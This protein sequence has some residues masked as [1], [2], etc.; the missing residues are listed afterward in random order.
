MSDPLVH[1]EQPE[2]P[3]DRR[4][5][6]PPIIFNIK[7]QLRSLLALPGGFFYVNSGLILAADNEAELAGVM[8]HEIAHVAA[9]H[10][11]RQATRG[12]IANLATIPLIFV[13]G[14][15]GYGAQSASSLLIPMGFMKFSRGFEREADYLG[16]QYTYKAGYYAEL[17]DQNRI[18]SIP[19]LAPR[20]RILDREGRTIA[21]SLP[22]F[23]ILLLR[24]QTRNLQ[25]DLPAIAGA[26]GI[27]PEELQNRLRRFSNEPEYQ[28]MVIKNEA[29]MADVD[30]LES[31][32]D[33]FPELEE[34]LE[35]RRLYPR[36]GFLAH[37]LGVGGYDAAANGLRDW[38]HRLGRSVAPAAPGIF[39]RA[40]WPARSR[41]P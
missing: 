3:A 13:G 5:K 39:R 34:A 18:K 21:D 15:I 1:S 8:A 29:T 6:A 22:S 28:P 2:P 25:G 31:H 4:I 7:E 10:G 23:A 38:R 19:L 40:A 32:R 27:P 35:Y 37:V 11:T 16:L 20:G 9:R 12:E 26:L 41:P 24:D 30:F 36:D 33:Q 17:A 14:G